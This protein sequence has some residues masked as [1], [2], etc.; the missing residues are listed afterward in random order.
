MTKPKLP[1]QNNSSR[2]KQHMEL[3]HLLSDIDKLMVEVKLSQ[4]VK[5]SSNKV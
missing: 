4:D 1:P 2:T 3:R 5:A